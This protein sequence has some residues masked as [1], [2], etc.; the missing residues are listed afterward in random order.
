MTPNWSASVVNTLVLA[1]FVVT[2]I[3]AALGVYAARALKKAEDKN[4]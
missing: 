4:K 3:G 1:F 2:A